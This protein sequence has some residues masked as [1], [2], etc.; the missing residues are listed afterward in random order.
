M[1]ETRTYAGWITE[2]EWGDNFDAIGLTPNRVIPRPFNMWGKTEYDWPSLE[3]EPIARMISEDRDELGKFVTLRHVIS[4]AETTIEEAEARLLAFMDGDQVEY[5][6]VWS[7]VTG[8]LWTEEHLKIGG[9]DVIEELRGNLTRYCV[10]EVT[11][12]EGPTA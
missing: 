6:D 4:D 1:S 5:R 9:H 3:V 7:D 12:A 8:Y 11:Y 2:G 10:I